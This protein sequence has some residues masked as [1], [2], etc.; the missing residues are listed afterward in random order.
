MP[1]N[2][3]TVVAPRDDGKLIDKPTP[4]VVRN[5]PRTISFEPL[6]LPDSILLAVSQ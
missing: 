5:T 4:I 1:R 6:G 3:N 2:Q